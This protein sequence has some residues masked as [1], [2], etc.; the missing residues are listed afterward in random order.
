MDHG[1][2]CIQCGKCCERWG[3]N[4]KGV[5]ED[6][7]P[8]V[9]TG[10]RDDILRYVGIWFLDG[11]RASGSTLTPADLPRIRSIRYWQDPAGHA[12]REC[13]FFRR[14]ADGKA[15]CG[16]HEV[17]PLICQT[18]TPWNWKNND[19]YGNCPACREKSP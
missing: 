2:D 18:F 14:S 5:V 16:I 17:K 12:L 4:Q 13:P 9:V 3:W 7:V 19:F 8:W 6:L 11:S 10:R 15:W 1:Q